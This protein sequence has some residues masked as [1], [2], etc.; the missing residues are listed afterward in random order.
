MHKKRFQLNHTNNLESSDEGPMDLK[1]LSY[2]RLLA[3][4]Y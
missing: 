3:K 2:D 4:G 1:L